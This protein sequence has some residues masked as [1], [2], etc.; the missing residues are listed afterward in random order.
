MNEILFLC[1]VGLFGF[2][3]DDIDTSINNIVAPI[4]KLNKWVK[5]AIEYSI[6]L[7]YL[8]FAFELLMGTAAIADINVDLAIRFLIEIV[9]VLLAW[10]LF[11][12]ISFVTIWFCKTKLLKKDECFSPRFCLT[13][14]ETRLLRNL[15]FDDIEKVENSEYLYNVLGGY[16]PHR[17]SL[18]IRLE[19]FLRR[20]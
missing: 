3:I 2:L 16:L 5:Y 17:K 20:N 8:F 10:V 7:L 19:E 11:I 15:L 14:E 18:L 1:L 12:T 6:L 4:Q 13:L 9:S